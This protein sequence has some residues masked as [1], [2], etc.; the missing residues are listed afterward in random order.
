ML[1]FE[2]F[3]A[4]ANRAA[5]SL[6]TRVTRAFNND[7]NY[8]AVLKECEAFDRIKITGR[9]SSDSLA[10]CHGDGHV[11]VFKVAR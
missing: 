1:S 3:K 9:A 8:V 11:L 5:G 4:E 2:E 7:G 6:K 10:F